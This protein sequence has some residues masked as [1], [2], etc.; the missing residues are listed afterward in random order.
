VETS[1]ASDR[2]ILPREAAAEFGVKSKTLRRWYAQGLIRGRRTLGGQ[3]RYWESEVRART[4]GL[5]EAVA[6]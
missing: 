1:P 2:L 6:S 5:D 3:M 4:A